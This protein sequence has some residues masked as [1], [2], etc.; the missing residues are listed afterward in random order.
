MLK[1]LVI[2][3]NERTKDIGDLLAIARSAAK[4]RE[5]THQNVNVR[6]L[7]FVPECACYVALYEAANRKRSA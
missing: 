2:Y 5:H 7:K 4:K 6:T 1:A 3:P